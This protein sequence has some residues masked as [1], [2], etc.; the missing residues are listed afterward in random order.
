[1]GFL[2]PRQGVEG[3]YGFARV[4]TGREDLRR[5]TRDLGKRFE[6]ERITVKLYACCK[7]FHS[8]L[9]AI[10]NCRNERA[11]TPDEVTAIE[12]F[13]PRLM[14]DTHMEYRP[15]STMAAQY[16]LPYACAAAIVL[17]PASPGSFDVD[18]LDRDDVLRIADLVSPVVDDKL[19]ALFPRKMGGGVRIHLRDGRELTSTV[20]DSRSSP[21]RPIG[22]GE[23]QDK[24]VRLTSG[25]M[26]AARQQ[27]VMDVVASLD[28]AASIRTLTA[29]LRDLPLPIRATR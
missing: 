14:I 20:I 16:S 23:V 28:K 10:G 9:E 2:G 4:F 5:V 6:V 1:M 21:D 25:L 15:A 8:M 12:P 29:L 3:R 27:E 17:D 18:V 13:G 11:F 24:F 19:E 7:L 22:R 26:N